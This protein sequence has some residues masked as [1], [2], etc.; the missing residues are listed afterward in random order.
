MENAA[1]METKPEQELS[2]KQKALGEVGRT[3][4]STPAVPLIRA[5]REGDLSSHSAWRVCAGSVEASERKP[6]P[7]QGGG[8]QRA[9]WPI[10][11]MNL[12]ASRAAM[13]PKY[14]EYL[15]NLS[16]CSERTALLTIN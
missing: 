8:F 3:R 5:S 7:P 1:E 13:A 10:S 6:G 2:T 11:Q 9:S 14:L 12:R 4:V 16:N 15:L